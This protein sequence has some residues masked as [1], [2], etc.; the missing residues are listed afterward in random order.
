MSSMQPPLLRTLPSDV[1]LSNTIRKNWINIARWTRN[2]ILSETLNLGNRDTIVQRLLQT[3]NEIGGLFA[4]YYGPEVGDSVTTIYQDYVRNLQSMI[5]A[6][7][8]SDVGAIEQA[9]EALNKNTNDL[10]DVLSRAN[11]YWDKPTL[12][13][14]FQVL[15]ES[16]E[17]QIA[18][19]VEGNSDRE[20]AAY[21]QFIEQV[22]N[23]SDELT[24]GII[25]QFAIE[26]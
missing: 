14:L 20:V 17:N 7:Q 16:N 12:Q 24:Y 21:D 25:R 13:I 10:A 6:Y 18:G 9:R 11:R 8:N 1:E 19:I 23:I 3:T 4:Q 2:F 26:R 5:I 22:Y 15:V